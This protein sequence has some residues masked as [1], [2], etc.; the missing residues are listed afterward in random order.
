MLSGDTEPWRTVGDTQWYDPLA[1]L[2]N[3]K[4]P[5]F[6]ETVKEENK[7]WKEAKKRNIA[8]WKHDFETLLQAALPMN[9]LYVDETFVW[10]SY[11]IKIQ[12]G[13]GH[14]QHVWFLKET[15]VVHTIKHLTAFGIDPDT[16]YFF[17]IQ[18]VGAGGE[19]FQLDVCT[20]DTFRSKWSTKP[21]GP[22][23]AFLKN[24]IAYQTVE[25]Y[26]RYPKVV[27]ADK[28]TGSRKYTAYDEVDKR[29]QVELT[30]PYNQDNV[31]IRCANALSQRIGY[32]VD[33]AGKEHIRWITDAPKKDA[34]GS[35]TSLFPLD[36]HIWGVNKGLMVN[37]TLYI[38][39]DNSYI[40]DIMY[41]S[42]RTAVYVVAVKDAVAQLWAFWLEHKRFSL[43]YAHSTPNNIVLMGDDTI[44][45]TYPYSSSIIY[46]IQN[47]ASNSSVFYGVLKFPHPLTITMADNGLAISKDGTKVPYTIVSH[48]QNPKGLIVEGYGSYGI[49][50]N[51]TY[52]MRW[53]PW[54]K[55]G[56]AY[57]VSCPRGGRENGDA[58]YDG[59]RTALRKQNT[60]D[61]T[62]AVIKAVQKRI[63]VAPNRTIFYGR[64][65]GGLLAAN[66]VHQYSYLVGA[67]YTEVPYVDV[68]RT[69][70]NP[71]L[72]LT[73]L[74]FDEFGD[75][76]KR[77]DEFEALQRISPVDT[78]PYAPKHAPFIV[79]KTGVN[80]VQVLPYEALK[81]AKKLRGN[82]WTVYVGIDGAGGHF[83]AEEDMYS[84]E[85]EDAALVHTQ[86]VHTVARRAR[87]TR[88][89]ISKGTASRRTRA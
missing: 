41:S 37:K 28:H 85:A 56:Y 65:A 5:E 63:H 24:R 20:A 62:A 58:W 2:E 34:D 33:S 59:A 38:L 80:D 61:D 72:P 49:S 10:R 4:G 55:R 67:I 78:V 18:D 40:T 71:D 47:D 89:H 60:F 69:T 86:L 22:N 57:A 26:Q 54:I 81:W 66:I 53:L 25:N 13:Y 15:T 48:T 19:V 9:P 79:V 75:P 14:R 76:L 21:V 82:N 43:V 88:R 12:Y 73:Q 17:I 84:Q 45:C 6:T 46:K 50:A 52:P 8:S 36:I 27:L 16:D 29:F 39:P 87:K 7:R 32:V 42:M 3:T 35:G 1:V 11:T 64:S 44:K 70:S 74:E 51:R 68:L 31:F 77:P 83:A 30:K 23:A